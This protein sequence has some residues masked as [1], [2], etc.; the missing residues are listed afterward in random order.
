VLIQHWNGQGWAVVPGANLPATNN[1]L[2]AV[3]AVAPDDVWAVGYDGQFAFS[4]LIEHWNGSTWTVVPSFDPVQSSNILYDVAAS[5]TSDVWTVGVSK[6][7]ITNIEGTLTEHW[8]GSGW[9]FAFG[10]NDFF[11]VLYGVEAV[12]SNEAWEVGDFAG[13]TVIG[14]WDGREWS[15]FPS[16]RITGRLLAATAV[17]P[18]DVWAVGWRYEPSVGMQTLNE[19]YTLD[20]QSVWTDVGFAL[21]GTAGEPSLTGT[22]PLT[23]GSSG[24]LTLTRAASTAASALFVSVGSMP[25]PFKGGTL[26]ALPP[27]V[28]LP[29]ITSPTGKVNLAFSDWPAGLTGLM[30]FFQYAIEDAVAV[31]GVALSNGLEADVP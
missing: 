19:H 14:R 8:S 4:T 31:H 23:P 27:L 3:T 17:T 30:L 10:I 6:N 29:A 2:N 16:P 1:E 28:T 22:G 18:C 5:V 26:V 21:A 15:V 13:L 12:S 7:L 20:C 25:A 9:S 11:S 24:A